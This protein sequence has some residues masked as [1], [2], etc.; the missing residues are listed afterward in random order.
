MSHT[1]SK[2][3]RVTV[4]LIPRAS[5]ALSEGTELTGYSKTDFINRAIMAYAYFED[6]MSTGGAVLVRE[7]GND[8]LSMVRFL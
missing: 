4:N 2:L 7:P 6:L 5:D 8:E 1:Q 3:E